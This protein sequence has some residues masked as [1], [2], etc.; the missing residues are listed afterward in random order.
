MVGRAS[1]VDSANYVGSHPNRKV[2]YEGNNQEAPRGGLFSLGR[3]PSK[4]KVTLNP[5]PLVVGLRI[6]G[7]TPFKKLLMDVDNTNFV[8]APGDSDTQVPAVVGG[9]GIKAG[10]IVA[11][12]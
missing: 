11:G 6:K 1:P 2:A 9:S 8:T 10:S 4:V 12:P 7:K 5:N 3:Q